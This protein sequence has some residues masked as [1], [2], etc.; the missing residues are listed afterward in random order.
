MK[1]TKKTSYRSHTRFIYNN[2]T[3]KTNHQTVATHDSY[4]IL[5]QTNKPSNPSHTRLIYI[6]KA[7]KQTIKR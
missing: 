1:Q 4:I 2:K 6:I 5:K 7:N 3:N